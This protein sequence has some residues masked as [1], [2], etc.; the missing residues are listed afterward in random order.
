MGGGSSQPTQTTQTTVQMS[1]EQRELYQLAIPG[2]KEFAATVPE[3]YPGQVAGFDPAQ[4]AG[5]NMALASAAP[6]QVLANTAAGTSQRLQDPG[7]AASNPWLDSAIDA[8]VR[9]IT[10]QYQQT[11]LPGIRDEF[12]GAG[13]GF[14]GSRRAIADARATSDYM[15][16]VG[17]TSAKL[18]LGAYNTNIDAMVKALGLTPQ[19]QQAQL[20]PG[21]TTSAV[22]DVRQN[23]A[24]QLLNEQVAG[25]NYAQLA[26][27]LQ[28]QDIIS[29]ISGIPGGTSTSLSTGNTAQQNPFTKLLG[30][31]AT[32]ASLGSALFPGVG[33]AAG[34]GIGG[35]LAFL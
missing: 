20:A 35:L 15:R 14:G 24:Q 26:P 28:S 30:G 16:S 6:Q 5:Q 3:R 22:G 1:P 9:P 31:A 19:T 34:A 8:S 25:F 7:F 32:G 13:Q 4:T 2:V 27:F 11:I 17:D 21:T 12:Q 29:L 10:E 23:L 33:T 18:G